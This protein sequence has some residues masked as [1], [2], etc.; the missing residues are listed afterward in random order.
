MK[1]LL[2]LLILLFC[3]TPLWGKTVSR[4]AA[5]INDEVITTYQLDREVLQRQG[6]QPATPLSPGEKEALQRRVLDELIAETLLQQRVKEL[7]LEVTEEELEG[8]IGD[9]MTQNSLTRAQLEEA[10]EG[11]GLSFSSYRENLKRQIVRFKL[12]RREVQGQV[13]VTNQE[14]RDYYEQSKDQFVEPGGIHLGRITLPIPEGTVAEARESLRMKAESARNR[15]R[16]G[17]KV[18]EVVSLANA[19]G[20]DMGV[21]REKELIPA[22]AAAV[23]G[24]DV[25]GV[26][27]VVETSDGFHLLLVIERIPGE[28]PPLEEVQ[29]EVSRLLREKKTEERFLQ[30]S[31]DLRKKA[32]IDIRL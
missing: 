25:G 15:L 2:I 22:F 20:V 16:G 7:G 27:Q 1:R 21:L 19:V 4:I 6:G 14:V 29:E 30:W 3:A 10:V 23:R 32:F 8:A 11:Q 24:I 9:I 28:A 13:E 5:V 12:L 17:A 31:E 26:S 18:E